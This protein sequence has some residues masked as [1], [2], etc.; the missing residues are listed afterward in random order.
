MPAFPVNSIGDSSLL[1]VAVAVAVLGLAGASVGAW[2]VLQLLLSRRAA[3]S[4]LHDLIEHT[5]G[6]IVTAGLDGRLLI[7]NGAIQEALGYSLDELQR[8]DFVDLLCEDHAEEF[9][10]DLIARLEAGTPATREETLAVR[11]DGEHRWIDVEVRPL[12]DLSDDLIGLRA[13]ARDITNL[14]RA[15]AALGDSERRLR[16]VHD[17]TGVGTATY[18]L[19]TRTTVWSEQ[20]YRVLGVEPDSLEASV[21]SFLQFIVPEERELVRKHANYL[22]RGDIREVTH[23]ER[24]ITRPDGSTCVLE[25]YNRPILDDDD[26]VRGILSTVRDVSD[27]VATRE[28][29]QAQEADLG[30][31]QAIAHLGSYSR[32][33]VTD[34]L[35]WSEELYRVL[36]LEPGSED[37]PADRLWACIHPDD[38]PALREVIADDEAGRVPLTGH[39][40]RVVWPD[41][42]VRTVLVARHND[43]QP[44]SDRQVTTVQDITE[45][46]E[47]HERVADLFENAADMMLTADRD[48]RFLTA[49]RM[50]RERLGYRMDELLQMQLGDVV[51][52]DSTAR[53]LSLP[54]DENEDLDFDAAAEGHLIAR[55]GSQIPVEPRVRTVHDDSG[56]AGIQVT[57][58][59]ISN[60]KRVEAALRSNEARLQ[61]ILDTAGDGIITIDPRGRVTSF[62]RGAVDIFGY[63]HGEVL[64]QNIA[65]LMLGAERDQHDQ[66]LA[67]Y[68]ETGRGGIIGIGREVIGLRKDGTQVPLDLTVVEAEIDGER[69]FT[70]TVRDIS[71]QRA[72]ARSLVEANE[73]LEAA[74]LNANEM[75]AQAL[76]ATV[77]KERFLAHMSHEIRTPMNGIVGMADLLRETGLNDAQ[78][79]YVETVRSSARALLAIINDILDFSKIESG[80]IELEHVPFDLRSV[81]TDAVELEGHHAHQ[82][83]V[84]LLL[85]CA[86]ECDSGFVG[87]PGRIRQVLLNLVSN[88]VKFTETGY[89]LTEVQLVESR[90][91]QTRVRISV[92]DTGIGIPEQQIAE[93]FEEFTQADSSTTRKYGGTGLGLSI[94]KNLVELMGGWIGATSVVNEGSTFSFELPLEPTAPLEHHGAVNHGIDA[95]ILIMDNRPVGRDI[96]LDQI[97]AWGIRATATASGD[98]T[99]QV[100][101]A[102]VDANDRYDMAIFRH[103]PPEI[104]GVEVSR[105]I[106]ADPALAATHL[107]L[108]TN[109]TVAPPGG[110]RFAAQLSQPVRPSRLL[111]TIA[112]AL[113]DQLVSEPRSTVDMGPDLIRLEATPHASFEGAP[114]GRVLVVEDNTNNQKVAVRMLKHLGYQADVVDNGLEAIETLTATT[115]DAV[116]M[117]GQM[118]EMDGYEATR[119]IRTRFAGDGPTIIAMTANTLPGDRERCLEAGMNDYLTKPIELHALKAMLEQWITTPGES[120]PPG[121]ASEAAPPT[122]ATAPSDATLTAGGMPVDPA[123]LEL[124]GLIGDEDDDSLADE[125]GDDAREL[126]RAIRTSLDANDAEGVR[127]AAHALKGSSAN[128]GAAGLS[129]IAAELER[130]GREGTLE[131]GPAL[132]DQADTEC[133][134]VVAAIR[135]LEAAA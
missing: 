110:V 95:R 82:R 77:A 27:A 119:Q 135:D 61:S 72:A 108:L 109:S 2:A 35:R 115:Y 131:A 96:L 106:H 125:F 58:R 118:P 7:A 37:L 32:D 18:N 74:V 123:R 63:T 70:G 46:A 130:F 122:G 79:D 26:I 29:L 41:G 117:D 69:V 90:D 16:L 52:L 23:A 86:P 5:D 65:K 92:T 93:L 129:A 3:E 6:M 30:A 105:Q 114:R 36:G 128:L 39:Q 81:V 102:A 1:A 28:T 49:N 31:A 71:E 38:R 67:R 42:T 113:G 87:D 4:G 17:V 57:Y 54:N 116:L 134:R 48:G 103:A 9:W 100:L 13:H 25:V 111:D 107:V 44:Q 98:E 124:L 99:L 43:R 97:L 73:Q 19:A 121:P 22:E 10:E 45:L 59:D 127:R 55:D 101:R 78:M 89:V 14:K 75:A 11:R 132:L 40:C 12:K 21:D 133:G 76:Q 8:M 88:A 53:V 34:E 33:R 24:H 64:G 20:F 126:L 51:A 83:G 80:S 112:D 91:Q 62:S 56:A 50:L 85:R 47:A 66:D 120:A 68:L 94:S 60:R 84:D 15:E 104:D